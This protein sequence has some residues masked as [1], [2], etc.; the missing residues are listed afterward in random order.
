MVPKKDL[1][2]HTHDGHDNTRTLRSHDEDLRK[3]HLR[4]QKDDATRTTISQ[5]S[6]RTH[7]AID[8]KPP[9][10]APTVGLTKH[11]HDFRDEQTGA[12]DDE[13]TETFRNGLA[14]T[15]IRLDTIGAR[16][17]DCN[18]AY[19]AHYERTNNEAHEGNDTTNIGR[20]NTGQ[21]KNAIRK[22]SDAVATRN[23]AHGRPTTRIRNYAPHAYHDRARN[24]WR[25]IRY[26][27][28]SRI[29]HF[30]TVPSKSRGD[31]R[32]DK[33]HPRTNSSGN[34]RNAQP[35]DSDN[36]T[37]ASN[38][39]HDHVSTSSTKQPRINERRH[40]AATTTQ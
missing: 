15:T 27:E 17:R 28:K 31:A 37:P 24:L 22:T 2:K 18:D 21:M 25:I 39:R 1:T 19:R 29:T 35:L 12:K 3:P 23:N 9:R 5:R 7:D 20:D 10:T 36:R 16:R 26:D 4:L 30:L 40:D 6:R 34:R 8:T 11:T 32:S 38:E 13:Q 14:K 33:T